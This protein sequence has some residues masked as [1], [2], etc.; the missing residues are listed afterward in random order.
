[1]DGVPLNFLLA[2]PTGTS[3]PNTHFSRT[4]HPK[5]AQCCGYMICSQERMKTKRTQ[6]LKTSKPNN[7]KQEKQDCVAVHMFAHLAE[8][9]DKLEKTKK[10]DYVSCPD[11]GNLVLVVDQDA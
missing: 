2:P 1:M 5:R 9:A 6:K 3:T 10:H 8:T 7:N 4:G 11:S